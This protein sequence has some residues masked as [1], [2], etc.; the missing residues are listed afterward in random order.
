MQAV[1]NG[2]EQAFAT[3]V[4]RHLDA[5][6]RYLLRHTHNP[7]DADELCQESFLKL[8]TQGASFDPAKGRLTTWLHR[9][10][11]HLMV[12]RLR[13]KQPTA[14]LSAS[15]EELQAPVQAADPERLRGLD[16]QLAALPENQ[17]W[18][19]ALV[20]LQGFS[21]KEAAH[22]M[23]IGRRALESLV[24]RAKRA[25]KAAHNGAE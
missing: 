20:Y 23:G 19:V 24:A 9:I 13:R 8:W 25:L 1:L 17:R 11:H 18:A 12:D 21:N 14:E 3:L 7:A 4:E 16:E 15:T 2:D 6:H 22:I 10:A 5:L